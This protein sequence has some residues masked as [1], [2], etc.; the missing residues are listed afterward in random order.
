MAVSQS[1]FEPKRFPP[2]RREFVE[3][4][5]QQDPDST[6]VFEAIELCAAGLFCASKGIT[7]SP[8]KSSMPDEMLEIF[9]A[10]HYLG[11]AQ[12]LMAPR[13]GTKVRLPNFDIQDYPARRFG[14]LLPFLTE[15]WI[16]SEHNYTLPPDSA[17]A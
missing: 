10:T 14:D 8:D 9:N 4:V 12:A 5:K 13:S 16:S 11:R 15:D 1:A 3:W 6:Y 7:R 2:I 17:A